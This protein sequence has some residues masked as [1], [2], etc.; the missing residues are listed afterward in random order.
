[1]PDARPRRTTSLVRGRRS[2]LA[3]RRRARRSCLDGYRVLVGQSPRLGWL[4]GRLRARQRSFGQPSFAASGASRLLRRPDAYYYLL[5]GLDHVRAG[6]LSQGVE[7]LDRAHA[8]VP[9]NGRAERLARQA[10]GDLQVLSG[11]WTAPR[12]GGSRSIP[13]SVGCCTW[14]GSRSRIQSGYTVR[15]GA[16]VAAQRDVGLDPHVATDEAF[17]GTDDDPVGPGEDFRNGIAHHRLPVIPGRSPGLDQRLNHRIAQGATV[18]ERVRPAVLHAA[19]DFLNAE[20][21]LA[22]GR[23]YDIPVVY[24]VRGFWRRPGCRVIAA[25]TDRPATCISAAKSGSSRPWRPRMPS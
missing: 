23:V 18:V 22:W 20:A 13:S 19:S 16:I 17:R 24:E 7:T 5:T 21:A 10:A 8:L 2:V 15:T 25:P 3:I 6:R 9:H 1:M 14:W 12:S 11:R 4:Y